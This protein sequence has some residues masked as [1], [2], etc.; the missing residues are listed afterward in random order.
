M[1]IDFRNDTLYQIW[2]AG[3]GANVASTP[4]L[5]DSD[6]DGRLDIIYSNETDPFDLLSITQ[7]RALRVSKVMTQIPVGQQEVAWG[8]Y[9]GS[10]ADGIFRGKRKR[11]L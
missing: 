10:K 2:E 4:W 5:G 9:M 6:G 8:A 7:K 3:H 11:P 1:V